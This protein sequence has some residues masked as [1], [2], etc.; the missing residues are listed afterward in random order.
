MPPSKTLPPLSIITPQAEGNY[1]FPQGAFLK[2]YFSPAVRREE[3]TMKELKKMTKI[4]LERV[5]VASFGKFHD[6][7]MFGVPVLLCHNLDSSM[8]KYEGSLT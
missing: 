8:L 3:E 5:M 6:R 2:N 4:K 7:Y 1:L